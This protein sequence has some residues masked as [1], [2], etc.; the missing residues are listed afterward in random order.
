VYAHARVHDGHKG[1]FKDAAR[2][3]TIVAMDPV[4]SSRYQ[5]ATG[6]KKHEREIEE[7]TRA[8]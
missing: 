5:A 4:E 7:K 8:T 2:L 3:K 1:T 6:G